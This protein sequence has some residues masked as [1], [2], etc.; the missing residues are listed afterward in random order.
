MEPLFGKPVEVE[1]RDL[2]IFS[3]SSHHLKKDD[4]EETIYVYKYLFKILGGPTLNRRV[5]V[6][7]LLALAF[8]F[9]DTPTQT[10]K[11]PLCG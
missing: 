11:E 4:E 10:N 7:H 8:L 2:Y 1:V 3:S 6:A 5:G 9:T